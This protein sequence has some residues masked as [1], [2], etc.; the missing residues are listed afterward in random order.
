MVKFISTWGIF[1]ALA[2]NHLD[3]GALLKVKERN[4]TMSG[5]VSGYKYF[6]PWNL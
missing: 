6:E 3:S 4:A 1:D 2:A 5:I